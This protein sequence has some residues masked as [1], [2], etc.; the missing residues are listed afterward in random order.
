[1][2]PHIVCP[3]QD[4]PRR[5][6]IYGWAEMGYAILD[7]RPRQ[8]TIEVKDIESDIWWTDNVMHVR[9]VN[10]E[11]HKFNTPYPVTIQLGNIRADFNTNRK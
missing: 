1:M 3:G 6:G 11:V 5:T 8:R 4:L 9:D 2:E 7:V 10:G